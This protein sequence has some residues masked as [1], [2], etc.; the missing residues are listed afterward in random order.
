MNFPR[1][2]SLSFSYFCYFG[3]LGLVVPFLPVFLDGRGFSSIQI[4]EILAIFTATKIIGPT[5]WA[6][7]ADKSGKQLSIIQLGATLAF[8][9]FTGLFWAQGYWPIAF[10]LAI[11]SLFWT[12]ILPQLEVMTMLSIRRHAKIYSR[13]RLWGSIGFIALAIAGGEIIGRYNADSFTT[14]GWLTLLGLALSS[15]ILKQ[16]YSTIKTS[17][18]SQSMFSKVFNFSFVMFFI[19]GLL[20]QIS[21]GPYYS[22]FA[23]YLRDLAY[24]QFAV[25][26]FISLGVIAE[27]GIFVVAGKLYKLFGARVLIVF[28]LFITAIRWYLTA[29]YAEQLLIL[30]IAQLIHAASFGLYHSAAMQFLQFHFISS[31][32]NRGQAIYIAGVYGIGGAIGAYFSGHLWQG[33]AGAEVTFEYAAIACVIA[34]VFA[35]FIKERTSFK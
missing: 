27:I 19:A 8:L 35:L 21:F 4:G 20:L 12:A 3:V 32:Q 22:F 2:Y 9:V 13:I 10:I 11:F 31:Q 16:P 33:G 1:F 23:L 14:I 30:I 28:S 18:K 34:T 26:L 25:G 6:M 5:L 24:P 7:F 17:Q 15:Y 29:E